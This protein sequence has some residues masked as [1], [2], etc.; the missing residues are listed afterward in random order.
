MLLPDGIETKGNL[1]FMTVD[2]ENS[3]KV[4]ILWLGIC[5]RKRKCPGHL[6]GIYSSILNIEGKDTGSRR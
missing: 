3:V 4:G 1:L 2:A 5:G 6:C